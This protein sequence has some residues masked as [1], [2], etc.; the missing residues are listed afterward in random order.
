M[1]RLAQAEEPKK[2]HTGQLLQTESV[3]CI[4]FQS[5][6]EP[7][8]DTSLCQE[9]VLQGDQVLFHFR[10]KDGKHFILLPVGKTVEYRQ[11][12]S[13]FYLRL[14]DHKDHEY[15][16]LS[17]EPKDQDSEPIRSAVKINH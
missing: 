13:H 17:M 7:S 3:Q 8:P 14:A 16:V 9:Y 11:E 1:A 15:V 12:Q 2:Y 5:Q 4:V 6:H 10:A